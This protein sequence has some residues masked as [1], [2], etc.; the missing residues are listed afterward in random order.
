LSKFYKKPSPEKLKENIK[1][2]KKTY[3]NQLRELKFLIETKKADNFTTEMYI[4]LI[5][6]RKITP[7]MLDAINKIIKRNSPVEVEKK[8]IEVTRLL[9]KTRL[10]SELLSKCDYHHVYVARS[11]NF[12]SSIE[13]SIKKWGNLTKNQKIAL[14]TMYKRFLKK[15]EK[16]A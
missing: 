5:G 7:K 15:S 9:G 12:I 3:S 4:A 1:F 13:E 6:G 14:N 11:E 2:N 8:R 10:V 16:K